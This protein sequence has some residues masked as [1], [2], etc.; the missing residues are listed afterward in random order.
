MKTLLVPIV[1]M[2]VSTSAAHGQRLTDVRTAFGH[3]ATP[4]ALAIS[5]DGSSRA[6]RAAWRLVDG[7][8]F[9]LAVG[10]GLAYVAGASESGEMIAVAIAGYL[11]AT[12]TG[13]A[14]IESDSCP[15]D[16]RFFRA[17][18]GAVVGGT[19]GGGIAAAIQG[20]KDLAA[21]ATAVFGL[22]GAP[23][24]AAWALW[25]CD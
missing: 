19:V 6:Q 20:R 15:G 3:P 8:A 1:L 17:L 12:A 18:G 24:G 21:V 13:A 14:L 4:L 9:G 23:A 5:G 16:R 25:K 11:V 10:V 7:T 22:L 2:S